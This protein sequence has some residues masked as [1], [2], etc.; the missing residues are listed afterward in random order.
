MTKRP[1]NGP[2]PMPYKQYREFLD[3]YK[4]PFDDKWKVREWPAKRMTAAPRWVSVDLRDG[5]QALIN[6]MNHDKKLRFFLQLVK[7]GFKEI[8][9]GFPAAS[10]TDFDFCRHIIENKLIPDDVH[11]QVLTQ[12]R[13]SLIKRT[14]EALVGAK[15]VVLHIYNSTSE[16]QRRVV[17]EKDRAGIK[18]LALEGARLVKRLADEYL[19]PKGCNVRYEYSPESFTGTELDFALDVCDDVMKILAPNPEEKVILNL[20]STV[21]MSTP[22]VYAD[23]IEWM[24]AHI[25]DR[26]KAIVS[27]H[28]HNDRGCGI[29]CA[30]L[31]V[32]AGADRVEGCLFGNGERT[33]N[34]CLV[35]LA[36][37]LF[38][39]GI[40]P[41]LDLRDMQEI[42]DVAEY[43]NELKI[44]E[45]YPWAGS[46]VY[47]AFSGSHQD[48]IKKGMS[49]MKEK[50]GD[51]WEVPYLPIDPAHIGRSYEAIVRV[52]SQSGKGGIA[53]LLEQEFG[54]A[55]PKQAQIEFSPVIQEITDKS[56]VE[57]TPTSI[58]NAFQSYYITQEGG[59]HLVDFEVSTKLV[60]LAEMEKRGIGALPKAMQ[61]E[62]VGLCK[63]LKDRQDCYQTFLDNYVNVK[64]PVD[65][66]EYEVSGAESVTIKATV[67]MDG[68]RKEI[69]GKGNGPIDAYMAALNESYGKKLQLKSYEEHDVQHG[70]SGADAVCVI[71]I[72]NGDGAARYGAGISANTTKASLHAVTAAVNRA[73]SLKTEQG[74]THEAFE[75]LCSIAAT[76]K[77]NGQEKKILG[78]GNGPVAAFISGVKTYFEVAKDLKLLDYSQSARGA[79]KSGEASEAVCAICCALGSDKKKRRYGIGLDVNT[80]TASAKAIL[81]SVS[82]LVKL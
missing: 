18:A 82:I 60:A 2:S 20:P 35:T 77:H 40:D 59:Y 8:E 75:S 34:V 19:A 14:V 71:S 37:N 56:G 81:S 25:K 27:V 45:R 43:C 72:A 61:I 67:V 48:A 63:P 31:A 68:K 78:S 79:S 16:L 42:I 53:Y 22:N 38:S 41:E 66:V 54:I 5:N 50:A 13:E 33:G 57:I 11:I 65:L 69:V 47:T 1:A 36:M 12:C 51:P 73:V 52:N 64:K 3:W 44:P 70:S 15:N 58:Y 4:I 21:E 28:P 39:Q 24:C 29:A 55:L 6:P 17:F 74:E 9:V 76:V 23:Q 80:T 49:K 30:E 32:L 7:M 62:L 46:L 10:Q 26:Q